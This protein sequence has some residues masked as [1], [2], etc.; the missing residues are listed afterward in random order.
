MHG[1]STVL[2]GLF[3]HVHILVLVV[4]C[5]YMTVCVGHVHPSLLPTPAPILSS[6]LFSLPQF[7]PPS[8]I[9]SFSLLYSV[10]LFFWIVDV[11]SFPISISLSTLSSVVSPCFCSASHPLSSSFSIYLF[12][13]PSPPHPCP[14]PPFP[15]RIEDF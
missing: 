10:T 5:L 7:S 15:L 1:L 9:R 2:D 4:T 6:L 3:I 14:P 11:H 8:S 13:R 12:P